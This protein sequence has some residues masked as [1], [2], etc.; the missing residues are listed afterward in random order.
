M[1]MR[2][3][4][5]AVLV[6]ALLVPAATTAS[7]GTV[8]PA[9][10]RVDQVGYVAGGAKRAWLLSSTDLSGST[11]QLRNGS[12]VAAFT[13]TV[14]T[15]HG[16]W[17]ARFTHVYPLDFGSFTSSGTYR[18]MASGATSPP[19]RIGTAADLYTPW[20]TTAISTSAHSATVPTSTRVCCTASLRIATT[21]MPR[22]MPSR[23]TTPTTCSWAGLRKIGGPLNVEGGWFDAGDYIKFAGTTSFA[24]SLM[25]LAARD[26]PAVADPARIPAEARHGVSW[27]L[28]M[29]NDRRKIL[30]FQVGIGGGNAK[31]LGDHDIWRLPQSDDHYE[32]FAYRYIAH[33]PVFR[34]GP[35]GSR[36]TPSLAGRLAAVFGLCAQ[37]WHGTA[38]GNRCLREGQDVFAL[39]R[40]HHVG[41][42][43][44]AA[45]RDDYPED[46]WTDDLEYGAIELY[47]GLR[48]PGAPKP[49]VS[50]RTPRFY[51][52]AASHW[53]H[54][55][56]HSNKD[57]SDTFNLYDTSEMAHTELYRA[58]GA[59]GDGGLDVTQAQIV[60][61]LRRQ[62]DP[63]R[64][65]ASSAP[66]GFGGTRSDPS[67]HAFGLVI[68]GT[69]Y[70]GITGTSRYAGLIHDELNW[71]LGDNAWGTTFVVGA[72]TVFPVCMQDQV[73][74]LAGSNTASPP[75]LL[76]ASVDGPNSYIPTGFFDN[77]PACHHWGFSRFDRPN[78]HYVDRL[79][80]WATVEP[81]LDYTSL[82]LFAFVELA[83]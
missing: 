50:G 40:T 37:V 45:P 70:D 69:E 75:L 66:F 7:A 51:L 81:A 53:A 38:Y 32:G 33:R 83:G 13:G 74:N 64:K 1:R 9:F 23:T 28:K 25:L 29:W 17:N 80:S 49:V 55:Y 4:S 57:T 8:A 41:P 46:T 56:L 12:N 78:W 63:A 22:S 24:V 36:L 68:A 21:H 20:C 59:A 30:Y 52:W 14:G 3:L 76:G 6:G 15:D 73:S 82:S 61:D 62:L 71:A 35:P 58:I 65:R 11:F 60:A 44:T 26:H 31:I 72:G 2:V 77:A 39:A 42:Q 18:V 43:I 10:V 5:A 79:A 48:E 34:N 67:P 19:F 54:V 27:L 16:A 47:L